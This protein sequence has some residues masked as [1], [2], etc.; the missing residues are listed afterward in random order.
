MARRVTSLQHQY[1][2]VMMPKN[3][4]RMSD[5]ASPKPLK[6]TNLFRTYQVFSVKFGDGVQ[7]DWNLDDMDIFCGEMTDRERKLVALAAFIAYRQRKM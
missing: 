6:Q 7:L 1:E 2:H 3:N 4:T 5:N